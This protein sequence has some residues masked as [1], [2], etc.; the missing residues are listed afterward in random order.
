MSDTMG[1]V[2]GVAP[3][4]RV[5]LLVVPQGGEEEEEGED[6][7]ERRVEW[8]GARAWRRTHVS[9]QHSLLGP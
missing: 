3:G 1:D 9:K 5:S 6:G 2:R 4:A 7:G 8:P